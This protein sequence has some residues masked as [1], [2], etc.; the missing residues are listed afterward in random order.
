METIGRVRRERFIKGKTAKEIARD[1]SVSRNTVRRVPRSDATYFECERG[2]RPRRIGRWT[3]E[4][5]VLRT[6]NSVK[7]A[8]EQQ[9]LIR[10]FEELSGCGYDRGNDVRTH[11]FPDGRPGFAS[12][13]PHAV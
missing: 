10:I 13:A 11:A 1:L 9:T 3:E 12:L 7:P 6:G 8:R 5:V 2:T 4:V